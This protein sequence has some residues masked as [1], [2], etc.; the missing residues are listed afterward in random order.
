MPAVSLTRIGPDITYPVIKAPLT[1]L[2]D[3]FTWF[4]TPPPVTRT[5]PTKFIHHRAM[6]KLKTALNHVHTEED[7]LVLES[8]IDDIMYEQL[9]SLLAAQLTLSH[10]SADQNADA[11][12]A[13]ISPKP[14]R[15]K[16]RPS[17]KRL[18]SAHERERPSKMVKLSRS[19]PSGDGVGR[20]KC[21]KCGGTGHY[22]KTC[23]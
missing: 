17:S 19:K 8:G 23:K 16:G 12:P 18:T 2:G 3:S 9:L 15:T 4:Q 7:L 5:L 13:I 21:T 1:C 11:P 14:V 6:V 20:R 22:A 10:L